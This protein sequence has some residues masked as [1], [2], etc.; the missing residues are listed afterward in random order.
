MVDV[1]NKPSHYTQGD[2]ECVDAIKAAL[3]IEEFRGYC[4][5]NVIKYVWRERLKGG[6]EDLEKAAVYLKWLVGE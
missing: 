3:T 6:Q 1:V 2:V 5:G 4:K